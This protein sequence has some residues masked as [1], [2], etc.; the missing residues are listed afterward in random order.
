MR[1][2]I[3]DQNTKNRSERLTRENSESILPS[4]YS[5]LG[6]LSKQQEMI[7]IN[8]NKTVKMPQIKRRDSEQATPIPNQS[9]MKVT[10]KTQLIKQVKKEGG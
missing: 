4:I 5:S 6:G 8:K 10:Q 1:A 2:C 3:S 7:Q 9:S